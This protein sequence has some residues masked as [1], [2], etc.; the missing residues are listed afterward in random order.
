MSRPGASD[1]RAGFSLIEVI[2]VLALIGLIGGVIATGAG[3]LLRSAGAKDP[4]EAALAAIAAARREAVSTGLAV[5]LRQPENQPRLEWG[6]ESVDFTGGDQARLLPPDGGKGVLIGGRRVAGSLR[7][8]R[9]HP[10]GT[11]DPFR[12]EVTRAGR[13]YELAIDPWTC[14]VLAAVPPASP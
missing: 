12:L 8:V 13:T 5:D 11:C 1:S 10:D 4:E 3:A 14:A 9:F 7:S 6:A 2:V